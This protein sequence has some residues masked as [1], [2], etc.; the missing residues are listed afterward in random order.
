MG[1]KAFLEC[2]REKAP[3]TTV[4]RPSSAFGAG[5]LFGRSV[6]NQGSCWTMGD[7]MKEILDVAFADEAGISYMTYLLCP[8]GE[9]ARVNAVIVYRCWLEVGFELKPKSVQYIFPCYLLHHAVLGS[10]PI[11]SRLGQLSFLSVPPAHA[12]RHKFQICI[13]GAGEGIRT[14]DVLLG[15]QALYR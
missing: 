8:S 3:E 2:P 7:V 11:A 10:P 6:A 14:L 12:S 13:C 9:K 1:Y 4:V 5:N 15:K